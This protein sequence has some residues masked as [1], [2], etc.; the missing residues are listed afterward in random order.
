M[1]KKALKPKRYTNEVT[2][3]K[4]PLIGNNEGCLPVVGLITLLSVIFIEYK[5]L[6]ETGSLVYQIPIFGL[7]LPFLRFGVSWL[8]G[9][10]NNFLKNKTTNEK[11]WENDFPWNNGTLKRNKAKNYDYLFSFIFFAS[12][13]FLVVGF[14]IYVINET[15]ILLGIVI[16]IVDSVFW[17]PFYAIIKD[18][19]GFRTSTA[20]CKLEK[21]PYFEGETLKG[22]LSFSNLNYNV[23]TFEVV[24]VYVKEYTKNS[25]KTR[26][27]NFSIEKEEVYSQSGEA[28][29]YNN[30]VSV[31]FVI[32]TG[33]GTNK[34]KDL[35]PSYWVMCWKAGRKKGEFLVPIYSHDT[36]VEA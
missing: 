27:N 8:F 24:F 26:G 6:E 18:V 11:P 35:E 15:S 22:E 12:F 17:Y 30:N 32:P 21:F 23:R 16:L 36:N 14:A 25:H 2:L 1:A 10:I 7:S 13:N 34:L 29:V 31:E 28:K 19:S 20:T 5:V 3:S 9:P 4:G 33:I